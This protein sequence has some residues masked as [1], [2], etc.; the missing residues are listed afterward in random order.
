MGKPLPCDQSESERLFS[1]DFPATE[2]REREQEGSGDVSLPQLERETGGE[3][4]HPTQVWQ[5]QK[6]KNTKIQLTDKYKYTGLVVSS[7]TKTLSS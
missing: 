2:K 6:Y 7:P 3:G 4:G 1:V 5:I